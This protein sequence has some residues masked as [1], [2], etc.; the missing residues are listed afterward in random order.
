MGFIV[1]GGVCV[2]PTFIRD[3]VEDHVEAEVKYTLRRFWKHRD[4]V[5]SMQEGN[6]EST[7]EQLADAVAD[8]VRGS[9]L[10]ALVWAGEDS[11]E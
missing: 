9:L 6:F 11:E 1:A 4:P 2:R 8:S 10:D 5:E 3:A 7:L